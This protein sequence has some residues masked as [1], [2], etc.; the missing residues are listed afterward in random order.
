MDEAPLLAEPSPFGRTLYSSARVLLSAKSA[1]VASYGAS[2]WS[3]PKESHAAWNFSRSSFLRASSFWYDCT[4]AVLPLPNLAAQNC[5]YVSRGHVF[6]FFSSCVATMV[7]WVCGLGRRWM[8]AKSA[9]TK[10]RSV[11]AAKCQ[12]FRAVCARSCLGFASVGQVWEGEHLREA[13]R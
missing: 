9:A 6:C 12:R 4:V 10:A 1:A 5:W 11:W 2:T 7:A 3:K 8:F 13:G